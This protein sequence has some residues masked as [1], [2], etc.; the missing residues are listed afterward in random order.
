[1]LITNQKKI[2]SQFKLIED[3]SKQIEEMK[4]II[5]LLSLDKIE[6]DKTNVKTNKLSNP[7]DILK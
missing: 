4:T 6:L 2:N 3:Q 7:F 1:M 5:N